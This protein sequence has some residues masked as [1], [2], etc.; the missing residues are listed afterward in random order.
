MLLHSIHPGADIETI[1]NHTGFPIRYINLQRTPPPTQAEMAAL[2]HIDPG[3]L[4]NIEFRS[5]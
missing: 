1:A 3:D 5:L 2:Q 4:R